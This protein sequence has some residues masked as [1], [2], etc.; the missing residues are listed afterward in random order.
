MFVFLVFAKNIFCKEPN[1]LSVSTVNEHIFNRFF[2]FTL[3][4]IDH[5]HFLQDKICRKNSMP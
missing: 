2:F 3:V 4:I 5:S 1:K